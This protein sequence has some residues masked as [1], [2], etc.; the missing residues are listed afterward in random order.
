MSHSPRPTS[1][2]NFSLIASELL[3]GGR[4]DFAKHGVVYREGKSRED[5]VA[6]MRKALDPKNGHAKTEVELSMLEV[7]LKG[8]LKAAPAARSA[9]AAV[10]SQG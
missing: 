5:V 1:R 2:I 7:Y 10:A 6:A 4:L 9:V 3:F 8:L